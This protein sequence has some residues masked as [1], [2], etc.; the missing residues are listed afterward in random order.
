MC[1]V[2]ISF[3]HLTAVPLA[4]GATARGCSGV[5]KDPWK[6]RGGYQAL[7]WREEGDQ[8]QGRTH[9]QGQAEGP[10]DGG[11]FR[12]C[13]DLPADRPDAVIFGQPD[14]A[15]LSLAHRPALQHRLAVLLRGCLAAVLLN[16]KPSGR[17]PGGLCC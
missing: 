2:N 17:N 11:Q 3:S 13:P 7:R 15:P 1:Q 6:I 12:F 8:G 9:L 4:E 5:R 10:G 14:Q 16:E